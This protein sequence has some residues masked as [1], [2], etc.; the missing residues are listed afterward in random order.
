MN[1]G[2]ED[3]G[4]FKADDEPSLADVRSNGRQGGVS[5]HRA[6]KIGFRGEHLAVR[7]RTRGNN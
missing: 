6:L 5:S 7:Q 2:R 4:L 1:T 3:E